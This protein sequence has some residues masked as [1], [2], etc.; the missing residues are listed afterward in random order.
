M[1]TETAPTPS[2]PPGPT[3][4]L[5]GATGF[6][7]R[8]VVTAARAADVTMRALVRPKTATPSGWSADPRI[9]PRA[10]ELATGPGLDAALAGVDAVIHAA[11]RLG[12]DDAAQRV[13]TL[14]P[15]EAVIAALEAMASPRPRLVL[16]SSFSV[17]DYAGQ[18][19]WSTIDEGTPRDPH[20]ARRD[21]YARAKIAQEEMAEAAAARGLD[22]WILR[23]GAIYG[24]GRLTTGRLG[25]A[26][27]G[28]WL[29]PGG[30]A[31]VPAVAVA[32]CA[33]ALVRAALA[34]G[35]SPGP[36]NLVDPNPPRQRDWLAA[37][38]QGRAVVLPRWL[39]LSP[40]GL[41]ARVPGL[42]RAL[43]GSLRPANLA[44]RFKPFD[45]AD[46][47]AAEVLDLS[48]RPPFAETMRSLSLSLSLSRGG[49]A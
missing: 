5:T 29:C 47:K 28:L 11:G 37:A 38:G 10:V 22:V 1:S 13:D 2:A 32:H 41:A 20:P 8:A 18:P 30:D 31:P 12:G 16:V 36:L 4:A 23:P 46:E 49:P 35:P 15:T 33:Q 27:K 40:F 34:D 44:A 17:F 21:A 25:F 26:L 9:E 3:I 19:P 6:L 14:V 7:G 48:D 42:S 39:L 24:P 45:M 43:P